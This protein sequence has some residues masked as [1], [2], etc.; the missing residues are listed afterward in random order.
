VLVKFTEREMTAGV[1]GV[2]RYLFA[3][4]R[5][6]WRRGDA[7][8]AWATLAPIEKYN[9]RSAAGE[10][11]LPVLQALPERPTV[12]APPAFSDKEYAEAAEAAS[13]ALMEHRSPGAWSAMPERRRRRLVRTTA[14]LT[15]TAVTAMPL[16]QDPDDLTV[17]DHL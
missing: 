15:R 11:V 5:P 6:P 4:T 1:D 7:E 8:A 13:Q 17:P 9:R 3:A 10:I 12:G 16:R 2:A 14:R